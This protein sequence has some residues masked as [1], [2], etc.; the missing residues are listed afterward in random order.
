M[1]LETELRDTLL[2]ALSERFNIH[3]DQ[4]LLFYLHARYLIINGK[5]PDCSP[6]D[7][8]RFLFDELAIIHNDYSVMF[9]NQ[10]FEW[11]F[12]EENSLLNIFDEWNYR[13]FYMPMYDAAGNKINQNA[14]ISTIKTEIADK[15]RRK[16]TK[17][18]N[19]EYKKEITLYFRL[20]E[21]N[22][23]LNA[24]S[25]EIPTVRGFTQKEFALQ[26]EESL[27]RYVEA[28]DFYTKNAASINESDLRDYLYVN[29]SKIEDGLIP[30]G[31]EE[32]IEEGRV[33]IL[34]VDKNRNLVVIELKIDVDKRLPWQCLYY[35]EAVKSHSG[36]YNDIR[37]MAICPEY[38]DYMLT[39]LNKIPN[40]TLI[41]YAVTSNN[42]KITN[43][44]F[45]KRN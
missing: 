36:L 22:K 19:S 24:T 27:H 35:P 28:S 3:N 20:T 10:T 16:S 26:L 32:E 37:M 21:L 31:K 9:N 12:R 33:D 23:M 17:Y 18:K 25:D 11:S 34:A 5:T 38:P 13:L 43:I 39:A 15:A 40:I 41:E 7:F 14:R 1:N 45:K 8:M 44:K 2:S 42:H 29:L 6:I 30:I 4:H